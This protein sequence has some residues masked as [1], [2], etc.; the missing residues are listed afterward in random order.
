MTT[1]GAVLAAIVAT[2]TAAGEPAPTGVTLHATHDG[3]HFALWGDAPAKPAP[4]LILL[5]GLAE[6]TLAK[7]TFQKAGK[8]L[9]PRGYLCVS[10]D[11][12]CHGSQ[13]AKGLSGLAG[14]AKRAAAADDFVAE[15]NRRMSAVL[16]FLI[17]Q[18]W[19][20]REKIA[21]C[22]T[23][24]GG[25]LAIRFAA[26]DQRVKAVA[27]FSPVTDLRQLSEFQVAKSAAAVDRM[28][29]E[30]FV[31][32]LVGRPI[33]IAIGDR[34]ERVGTEAAIAFARAL[35]RAAVRADVPSCVE[36]HVLS[37]PGGHTAPEGADLLAARWIYRL[38][39]GRELPN[40]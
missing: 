21:T 32:S 39:E 33:F 17:A 38:L 18:Q 6:D 5:A 24:R 7:S 16:D 1:W 23:S 3:V 8:F 15:F 19:T 11:L 27:A 37:Q 2:T 34:D 28:S 36:L 35:S 29:L 13:A 40:P 14:W 12:P 10:I 25:F 31:P 9:K 4:T 22:G 30:A 26:H 20:D